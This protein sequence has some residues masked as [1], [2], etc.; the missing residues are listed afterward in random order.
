MFIWQLFL[1][2]SA[3]WSVSWGVPAL[4]GFSIPA[5]SV[6]V[7]WWDP[8]TEAQ[9]DGGNAWGMALAPI[10]NSHQCNSTVPMN[11]V[12]VS[13]LWW[14]LPVRRTRS[15]LKCETHHLVAWQTVEYLTYHYSVAYFL[16][17]IS[18]F[19]FPISS[20]NLYSTFCKKNTYFYI[21]QFCFYLS[22]LPSAVSR[23]AP[24]SSVLLFHI[25]VGVIRVH[26]L[27]SHRWEL[28]EL[29]KIY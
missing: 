28:T 1:F 14:K 19:I 3:M 23:I 2:L 17:W 6:L 4:A 13:R 18:T 25:P 12:W 22:S 16:F 29:L 8:C 7:L 27:T 9:I 11:E 26:C 24:I 10:P 5:I 20:M 21:H 15:Y